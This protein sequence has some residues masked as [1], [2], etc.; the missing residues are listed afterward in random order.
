MKKTVKIIM[1]IVFLLLLNSLILKQTQIFAAL[2]N[3][4]L[5]SELKEINYEIINVYPHAIDAFTQGLVFHQGYLY[6]ST[7]QY[8]SSSLRKTDYQSGE[9]I[10]SIQLEKNYF[11]EGITIFDNKIYQLS[12]RENTAFVYDLDFNLIKTFNY[13]GEGWG[14]TA[15]ENYL[16][17]SDGS[18]FIYYRQADN[19]EIVKKIAITADGVPLQNINE[20]Q[21]LDGYL[22][23][24]IWLEDYIVKID[25]KK[26]QVKAYLDLKNIIDKDQ[27][28]HQLDVLN[29][30][31][32]LEERGSFIVTGK[33]WPKSF[34]IVLI[35]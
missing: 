9:I 27:Y 8:G 3:A 21:Y 17:M 32:Y 24:N 10:K 2:Q 23:A 35:D 7:G 11:A 28:E 31:A 18:Q 30:I 19:F 25:P 1:I 26:A 14:L 34:E 5:D 13:Q 16:I 20:L 33:L 6:E 4:N 15:N 22:Y 12:W 29:G